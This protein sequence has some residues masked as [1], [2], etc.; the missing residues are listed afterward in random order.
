[1]TF[2]TLVD[3]LNARAAE[4]PSA[5]AY[6]FLDSGDVEGTATELT[7]GTLAR[8]ARAIAATL[9]DR[10][11]AGERVLLLYPP[12]LD[13]VEGFFGC[14]AGGVVAVPIPLPQFQEFDRAM[15]RLRQVI[16]DAE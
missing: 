6:R 4:H 15:R 8:R 7:Y 9:H 1:M 14:L 3:A 12:G 10:G 11:L 5:P 2:S 13:F 16:A